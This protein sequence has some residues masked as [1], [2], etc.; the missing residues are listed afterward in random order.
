MKTKSSK[1]IAQSGKFLHPLHPTPPEQGHMSSAASSHA[2]QFPSS[3]AHP[4]PPADCP[5]LFLIS[6]SKDISLSYP[7]SP[8]AGRGMF[9]MSACVATK[10]TRSGFFSLPPKAEGESAPFESLISSLAGFSCPRGNVL[11]S[12]LHPCAGDIQPA[13]RLEGG[14]REYGLWS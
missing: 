11:A 3:D 10:T 2:T 4:I 5:H 12:S 13:H 8:P 14:T 6:F 7:N 9:M 1:R